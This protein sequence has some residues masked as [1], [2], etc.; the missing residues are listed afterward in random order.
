MGRLNMTASPGP[1]MGLQRLP[2]IAK[3]TEGHVARAAR[4][5]AILG[6]HRLGGHKHHVLGDA[7]AK[8]VPAAHKP[9]TVSTVRR[10][11]RM[12]GWG[13][14]RPLSPLTS[15]SPSAASWR[16]HSSLTHAASGIVSV[17][18]RGREEI[19]SPGGNSLEGPAARE[20]PSA[21]SN[22]LRKSMMIIVA[23]FRHATILFH[24]YHGHGTQG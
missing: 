22:M 20:V 11:A 4:D 16:G 3:V 5:C 17:G 18:Q 14:M 12:A 1:H 15:S 6:N 24:A 7:V 2:A 8:G 9:G 10:G 23:F 13:R 19:G 21:T